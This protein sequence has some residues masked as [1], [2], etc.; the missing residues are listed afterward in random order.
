[1]ARRKA[2]PRRQILPDP[3]FES[4]LLAEFINVVMKHGK[5]SLAESTVYGSL[6]YV[7]KALQKDPNLFAEISKKVGEDE[8]DEASEEGEGALKLSKGDIRQD[9]DV[10]E[11]AMA[12]FKRALK[13]ASPTVEVRS[14]RV[15]GS[16]Y[17]VPV[18]V[19][20]RRRKALGMRW[21]ADFAR[22]RSEKSMTLRLGNEILDALADRGG[23]VRQR[24]DVHRM[25]KS[26]QAF[27]H[28]RW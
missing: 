18:E 7:V 10:R 16:T 23:A 9:A 22:K 15:G 28:F 27:A 14:R 13:A 4:E 17:Q 6:D 5:K 11:L 8:A 20:P 25:A 1:M 24:Q 12:V 21:L 2:A 3:L 26:N 19:R